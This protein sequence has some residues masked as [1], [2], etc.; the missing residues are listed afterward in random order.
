MLS[1]VIEILWYFSNMMMKIEIEEEMG[2]AR[3]GA[4]K[5]RGGC[6]KKS[7]EAGKKRGGCENK[8]GEAGKKAGKKLRRSWK[9][10]RTI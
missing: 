1:H 4:E 2:G 7:G 5:T 3:G 6:E 9:K 8:S 10:Q